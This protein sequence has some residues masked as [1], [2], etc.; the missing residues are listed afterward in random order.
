MT[1]S[2]SDAQLAAILDLIPDAVIRVDGDGTIGGWNAGAVSL[3]GYS[4]AEIVGRGYR[5]LVPRERGERDAA[6]LR[7]VL[8]GEKVTAFQTLR[9]AKDGRIVPVEINAAP[10]RDESARVVGIW[11]VERA[12]ASGGEEEE[13]LGLLIEQLQLLCD[14][15]H[16]INEATSFN[17]ALYFV[18]R[19]V[20]AH[21]G[22][23]GGHAYL[24]DPQA[25]DGLT[26]AQSHYEH[27]DDPAEHLLAS[28]RRLDVHDSAPLPHRVLR[29]GR[30]EW[31]EDFRML[32]EDPRTKFAEACGLRL[33]VAF[34]I[35]VRERVVGVMEFFSSHPIRGTNLT[36]R[37]MESVGTQVGRVV[38]RLRHE[39]E[40]THI[41]DD[42][43]LR[44][45]SELHD[46]LGQTLVGLAMMAER[47]LVSMESRGSDAKDD[48]REIA[49]GLR[50]AVSEHRAVLRG[51]APLEIDGMSLA[52]AFQKLAARTE[53]RFGIRCEADCEML[54]PELDRA[55]ARN[56]Y[57][58][59]AEAAWNAVRHADATLIEIRL[60]RQDGATIVEVRDDGSGIPESVITAGS[61]G[62]SVMHYRART[63]GGTLHIEE[64][65][66]GGTCI[67]CVVPEKTPHAKVG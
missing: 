60:R 19:R 47:L 26:L 30:T 33:V 63:L 49:E 59:A 42:E 67:R 4:Q 38:E 11:T 51:I 61:V 28:S 9:C 64:R 52:A 17:E 53:S 20:C 7:R 5:E 18:L 29:T 22:W 57:R 13:E 15:T 23:T 50:E 65:Q 56:L 14:T 46:S 27:M 10:F 36:R 2:Q 21:N 44:I 43:Q 8:D 66:S 37:A 34:P 62:M 45:R 31:S 3:Y 41:A 55:T 35:L 16:L 6:M 40:L 58:I 32:I 39:H 24:A 25:P 54:D 1:R 48:V 12:P